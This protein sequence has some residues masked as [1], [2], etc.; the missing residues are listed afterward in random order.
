MMNLSP[1]CTDKGTKTIHLIRH[2]QAEHNLGIPEAD[3]I[4]DPELTAHGEQQARDLSKKV[5][6][7]KIDVIFVSSLRRAL[8]TALLVFEQA[9]LP[10][11]AT[12]Q[13]RERMSMKPCDVRYPISKTKLNY[14][15]V[16]F[17]LIKTDEDADV[18]NRIS[19]E[20]DDELLQRAKAFLHFIQQ[21]SEKNIA[22]VAHGAFLR[23]FFSLMKEIPNSNANNYE[24]DDF[25]NG[26]HRVVYLTQSSQ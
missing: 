6:Q 4:L 8:H 25:N 5:D 22:V 12:D 13:C 21:R 7:Y 26:E 14:S 17:L 20:L 11:L 15:K 3:K 10:L 2:G 16:D 18:K 1:P 19:A 9:N 23:N 24:G